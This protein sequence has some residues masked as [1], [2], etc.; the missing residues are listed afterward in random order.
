MV[1][2]NF[3]TGGDGAILLT[4]TNDVQ[5]K[6]QED[7]D[8]VNYL[9]QSC[10]TSKDALCRLYE[11]FKSSVFAVAFSITCDYHL[12]EDCVAETFVRLTQVKR[13]SPKEGD[14]RGFIHAVARNVA[15][16]QRRRYKKECTSFVIQSYGEADKTVE[17]SIFLNQMLK[18]LSDKQRQIV[19]MRCCS[20][21]SFKEIASIMKCPETTVKSRYRKA[22][23]ILQSKA[24]E[25]NE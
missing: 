4:K 12:S 8:S 23:A 11:M 3:I 6:Y 1:E 20:E 25:G 10:K 13:F 5:T 14:G 7:T 17:D 19:V 15:L 22:I 18:Y 9:I 21:L 2:Q 16:E 24:G